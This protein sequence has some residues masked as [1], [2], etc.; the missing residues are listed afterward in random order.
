MS[1]RLLTGFVLSLSLASVAPAARATPET[2][3]QS[4]ALEARGNARGAL[5][6]LDTLPEPERRGYLYALRRGWLLYSLGR[7]ADAVTA[8]RAA[9]GAAPDAVEPVLGE[10]LPLM[11][12][13]R[14]QDAETRAREVLRVD[15]ANYLA[16]RRLALVLYHLGRFAQSEQLYRQ[17]LARYPGDLEMLTGIGWC[18][19]RQNRR[20]DAATTFRGVLAVSADDA[21]AR[22]GLAAAT[23]Q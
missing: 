11:A 20:A 23:A 21:S 5:E 19:L 13:R 15:G 4:Y 1:R 17:V 2:W 7:H 3:R 12:L 9:A 6:A 10:L 22:A 16:N 8:Y 18:Q 14:W